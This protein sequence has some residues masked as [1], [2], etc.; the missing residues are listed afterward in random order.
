MGLIDILTENMNKTIAN[1][2]RIYGLHEYKDSSSLNDETLFD[3][4][5]ENLKAELQKISEIRQCWDQYDNDEF[6]E[7]ILTYIP[8]EVETGYIEDFVEEQQ[9]IQTCELNGKP[10][11][12]IYQYEKGHK[13]D[14]AKLQ[15]SDDAWNSHFEQNVRRRT[16]GSKDAANFGPCK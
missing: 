16:Q 11:V 12:P 14:R 3:Y 4:F 9:G 1:Y 6:I 15:A 2:K 5:F 8:D 13:I 10:I 7:D